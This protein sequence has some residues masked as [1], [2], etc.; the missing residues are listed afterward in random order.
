MVAMGMQQLISPAAA[1]DPAAWVVVPR[2]QVRCHR[3]GS[4]HGRSLP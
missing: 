3:M 4:L 2:R 1:D